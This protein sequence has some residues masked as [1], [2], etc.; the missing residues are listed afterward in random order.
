MTIKYIQRTLSIILILTITLGI[1]YLYL[2]PQQ[3]IL[4]DMNQTVGENKVDILCVGSSHVYSGINPIQLYLE[5]GYAAYD[6]AGGSMAPWQSYYYVLEA[7]KTQN[8]KIVVMDVYMLG[9]VQDMGY[10]QD[11]QTVSNLLT[12]PTSINK[13]KAL[14]ASIADSRCSIFLMFPYTYD[15]IDAY[16]GLTCNKLK[17]VN[18]YSLGYKFMTGIEEYKNVPDVTKVVDVVPIHP[19][20]EKYL[21]LLIEYCRDNRIELVLTNTPWPCITLDNERYFNYIGK[22]ADEYD[23][24]FLNGCLYYNEMGIDYQTDSYGDGG[25]LNHAGVSKYTGWLGTYLE[26]HYSLP[27]HR[28][29]PDYEVYERCAD[30]LETKIISDKLKE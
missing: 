6:L 11:Y 27:D 26:E 15:K 16:H 25:H 13:V 2:P 17:G 18:D 22:V 20:N 3:S 1:F 4:M 5:H 21:R 29:E 28:G 9:S 30:W 14:E 10:Y 8:P 19:K 23:V 24:P 7:C 12:F